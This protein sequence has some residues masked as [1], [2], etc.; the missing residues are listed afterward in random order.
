VISHVCHALSGLNYFCP[1][2]QGVALGWYVTALQASE[3]CSLPV[4]LKCPALSQIELF[5]VSPSKWA[6]LGPSPDISK[7]R[8]FIG[9]E[10]QFSVLRV[11]IWQ[12]PSIWKEG[13][14]ILPLLSFPA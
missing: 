6:K 10:P 2:S 7:A 5:F 9:Y 14:E 3:P 8:Q 11:W 12:R 13:F 4:G 1:W